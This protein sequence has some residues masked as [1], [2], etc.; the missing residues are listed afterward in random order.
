L[1]RACFSGRGKYNFGKNFSGKRDS[2]NF[3]KSQF[4]FGKANLVLE[5]LKI[6][7]KFV[8][9][10]S[11][12]SHTNKILSTFR[13]GNYCRAT[14]LVLYYFDRHTLSTFI[15]WTIINSI[16]SIDKVTLPT[17]IENTSNDLQ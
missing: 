5:I 9:I 17:F 7:I 15:L 10:A 6:S 13:H 12:R 16:E 11:L 3:G 8:N 14:I 2:L 4:S 1:S